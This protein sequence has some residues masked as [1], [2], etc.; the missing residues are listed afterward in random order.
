MKTTQTDSGGS[1]TVTDLIITVIS[2][3]WPEHSPKTELGHNTRPNAIPPATDAI[4]TVFSCSLAL[5]SQTQHSL[6][7]PP[8]LL[9]VYMP[10]RVSFLV[11]QVWSGL[12]ISLI[13]G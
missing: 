13:S 2:V 4:A 5:L 12:Y 11:L 9:I 1:D 6:S 3:R 7:W 10:V 8:L